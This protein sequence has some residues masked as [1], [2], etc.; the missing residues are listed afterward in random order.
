[1]LSKITH[2]IT[3]RQVAELQLHVP[4]LPS[5]KR[6][7]LPR[8]TAPFVAR[9]SGRVIQI[10]LRTLQ[11]DWTIDANSPST[12]STPVSRASDVSK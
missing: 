8:F 3:D 12:T 5:V 6:V 7:V 10:L 2:N 11:H 9:E 1:M 4:Q